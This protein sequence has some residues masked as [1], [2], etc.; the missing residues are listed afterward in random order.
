M[1]RE[2]NQSNLKTLCGVTIPS[3]YKGPPD[4]AN[5]GYV[6]SLFAE[7]IDGVIDVMIKRPTPL[8]RELQICT[9]GDGIYYLMDGDQ[10][11]I[12]AKP[13]TMDL[14]VPD[15]PTYEEAVRAAA[16]SIAL[17]PTPYTH[18]T[19]HGIHPICFCCGADVPE[20]EGLKIHPGQVLGTNMV[21]AP[22]TPSMEYGDKQGY[23]LPEFIWTALDCPGAYALWELTDAKPGF[24]GRLIGQIEKPLCCDEPCVV[25]AWPT[26]S[27]GRKLYTGT[28]LFDS[29]GH[30]IGR[31]LAT[32]F[33]M[34]PEMLRYLAS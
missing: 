20:G 21:A 29:Q 22:W 8:D 23:V 9:G 30:I 34:P 17:K 10:M 28:A 31:S 2:N 7:Y 26:G 1:L 16:A 32:W 25:A 15:A 6:C 5:G 33:L 3:K 18:V 24:L 11:I 4:I 19:G 13:G 27:D 12:Q 14:A